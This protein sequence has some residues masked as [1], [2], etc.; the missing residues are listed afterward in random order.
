VFSHR[1]GRTRNSASQ[2]NGCAVIHKKKGEAKVKEFPPGSF[3]SLQF[4]ISSPCRLFAHQAIVLSGV[5]LDAVLASILVRKF[6][7]N[8]KSTD[9]QELGND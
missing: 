6:S 8:F 1:G 5:F 7:F 9:H 4:S 3:I 2:N